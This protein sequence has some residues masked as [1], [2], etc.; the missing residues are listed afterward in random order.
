[1]TT[2]NYASKGTPI[3]SGVIS[4]TL[5]TPCRRVGLARRT[6]GKSPLLSSTPPASSPIIK[7]DA[8]ETSTPLT[9]KRQVK[10]RDEKQSSKKLKL[11]DEEEWIV[12]DKVEKRKPNDD[13]HQKNHV[14][15][16]AESDLAQQWQQKNQQARKGAENEDKA[17]TNE[18]H[19]DPKCANI[20][21]H[22]SNNTK[23]KTPSKKKQ[24]SET[25]KDK[26]KEIGQEPKV[27]SPVPLKELNKSVITEDILNVSCCKYVCK[28]QKPPYFC[29][30]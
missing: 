1:M 12:E 28:M 15:E 29:C 26:E 4:K 19:S 18:R 24:K 3:K 17:L 16:V 2:P 9:R 20:K 8:K 30:R 21:V 11:E 22:D 6:P 10:N 13:K 14:I 5:L 27:I 23:K 25:S 7:Q